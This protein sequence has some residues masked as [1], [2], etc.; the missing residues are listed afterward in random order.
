MSDDPPLKKRPLCTAATIVEPKLNVSGSTSVRCWLLLFVNGSELIW[1]RFTFASA[2]LTEKMAIVSIIM[3]DNREVP[4]PFTG[5]LHISNSS[6]RYERAMGEVC[7]P[8]D[9]IRAKVIDTSARIPKLTTSGRGLGVIKAYCSNCG[10]ELV[11]SGNILRCSV[12]RNVERRR[13]ADD[14][15]GN[16]EP[17]KV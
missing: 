4:R 1:T 2:V 9:L 12:C 11:L 14:F 17:E 10:G 7:K 5:M 13:L 3:V 16:S 6:P 8:V 15:L